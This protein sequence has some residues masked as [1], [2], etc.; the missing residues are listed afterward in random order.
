M[1]QMPNATC[2]STYNDAA[3][4]APGVPQRELLQV[5]T[6]ALG[7]VLPA[8]AVIE[9]VEVSEDPVTVTVWTS[10]P[11]IVLGRRGKTA[12]AIRLE[13]SAAAGTH[14]H[15]SLQRVE[16]PPAS[17]PSP[18]GVREPRVPRPGGS[19]VAAEFTEPEDTG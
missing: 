6:D 11:G 17:G 5:V 8:E 7:R 4:Y 12:E 9:A 14:V 2:R 13:L 16:E 19:P 15:L 1:Y 10:T 3:S 18:G